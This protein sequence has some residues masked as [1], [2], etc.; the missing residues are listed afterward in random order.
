MRG[1]EV[2][3]YEITS[4]T[5]ISAPGV[6]DLYVQNFKASGAL[7]AVT[8]LDFIISDLNVIFYN[9]VKTNSE[10]NKE[11]VSV[12]GKV[13]SYEKSSG[14]TKTTNYVPYHYIVNTTDYQIITN[15]EKVSFSEFYF[16][17]KTNT[18]IFIIKS[19][20]GTIFETKIAV[21]VV[22]SSTNIL[23][24]NKLMWYYGTVY[25]SPSADNYITTP[26]KELFLTKED[27]L[28]EIT[29]RWN[30]YYSVTYNKITC[31]VSSDEGQTWSAVAGT[32]E[33]TSTI[34]TLRKSSNYLFKF[35]DYAGN[36]QIF[37]TSGSSG[38]PSTTTRIAFIRSVIYKIN[39][40]NPLDNSVYNGQVTISLPASMNSYYSATPT[41]T[42]LKNNVA[43]TP[44]KDT[45]GNYV[46][47][48]AG[49]Y[50][51]Y[52]SVKVK[53]GTKNLNED[54]LTFTIVNQN[55]SRWAF[56]YA[57]Y[58]NYTINYIR[59]NGINISSNL[60]SYAING[61]EINISAFLQDSLGNKYFDNGIYT[62]KMTAVDDAL[63][64]Q[65]FEFSFW[66]N[67]AIPPI[68][69][70]LAEGASTTDTIKVSFNEK[71][72]Y[73]T[74]GDCYVMINDTIVAEIDSSST[75]LKEIP[76]SN[77]RSYYVQVYT[78]SGK[79]AYSYRVEITEPLNTVTIILIVVSCVVVLVGGLLFFLLRK[80]M[81]VR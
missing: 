15:G 72:L 6:Y 50:V 61:N 32:Q 62:I 25:T 20:S 24:S 23:D 27:G 41:L 9:V 49:T 36:T 14:S 77:I 69:V 66:L 42:V 52:F 43:Y 1:S 31:Y 57:N 12:T 51:I 47:T 65:T 30:S 74:I 78:N 76:L 21:T 53:N 64:T 28:S 45:S 68:T 2:G 8:S 29:L 16:D 13:F 63:G 46:F 11:V 40:E 7:D 59:Y 37:T 55:D 19:T 33:G 58:N 71:N 38:Y 54:K 35:V 10:G 67:D 3:Y 5:T 44:T 4:P 60:K 80:K 48:E 56:N 79:L 81:K 22:P 18:Q 75:G 70:S 34:L 39:G 17:E 26:T 73:E